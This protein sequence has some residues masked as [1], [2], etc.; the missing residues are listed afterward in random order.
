MLLGV[1][2]GGLLSI[3]A[4][5]VRGRETP[6]RVPTQNDLVAD[7]LG[8]SAPPSLDEAFLALTENSD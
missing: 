2:L 3:S 6:T 7:V 8:V 5:G 1:L 4:A